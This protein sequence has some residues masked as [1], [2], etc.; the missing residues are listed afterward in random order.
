MRIYLCKQ[1][2]PGQ[3]VEVKNEL[4]DLQK[5]VG[6]YIESVRLQS[7]LVLICNEEGKLNGLPPNRWYHGDIICGDFFF[8]GDDGEDF[9]DVPEKFVPI[10]EYF[11]GTPQYDKKGERI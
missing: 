5:T 7:N 2:E 6:G 3:L 10:L 11:Y 1:G 4:E 9:C 8:C